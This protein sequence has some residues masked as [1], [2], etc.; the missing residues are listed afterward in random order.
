MHKHGLRCLGRKKRTTGNDHEVVGDEEDDQT[1]KG[2]TG[3]DPKEKSRESKNPPEEFE[4]DDLV[5]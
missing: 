3:F 4:M 2:Q 1:E 5:V